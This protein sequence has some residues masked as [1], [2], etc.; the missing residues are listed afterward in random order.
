MNLSTKN[1]ALSGKN[2]HTAMLICKT[3]YLFTYPRCPLIYPCRE[4]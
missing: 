4:E 1:P 2:Y 3:H